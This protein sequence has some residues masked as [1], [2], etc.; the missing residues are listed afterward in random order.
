MDRGRKQE[1]RI[2]VGG[3][4]LGMRLN[5]AALEDIEAQ[6][7]TLGG[8]LDALADGERA[9][10]ALLDALAI[11]AN[12]ELM[13]IGEEPDVTAAWLRCQLRPG[14][15]AAAQRAMQAAIA[16]GLR[17]EGDDADGDGPVD[18]LLEEIEAKKNTAR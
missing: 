10:E 5:M 2:R 12:G 9:M 6:Y 18:V 8:L 4:E 14:Q 3:R 15:L 11:L 17:I 7:G 13:A 1:A 16:E